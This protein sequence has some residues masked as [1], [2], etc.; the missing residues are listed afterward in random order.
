[1]GTTG[2]YPVV[3]RVF[4][5]RF[6]ILIGTH[7]V[8][9]FRMIAVARHHNPISNTQKR[10]RMKHIILKSIACCAVLLPFSKAQAV[11][12]GGFAPG[13]TFTF[14]VTEKVSAKQSGF[15]R[16][17]NCP[18]PSGIPNFT[19]GKEVKFTIG[20]KGQLIATGM[21]MPFKSDAG[22]ANVY[23]VPPSRT[24]PSGDTGQVFK[25]SKNKPTA[26][27]L[28]FFKVTLSGFT[29]TTYTVSYTLK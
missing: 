11:T 27:A 18:V 29:P 4:P 28:S 22:T 14:T 26:V 25:T 6:F 8:A 5:H 24:S 12:Y 9:N 15:G 1:L 10:K 16:P 17:V 19:K 23:F 3:S 2:K 21:S 7:R 20:P 13:K